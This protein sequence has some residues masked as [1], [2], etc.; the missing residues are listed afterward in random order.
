[1]L[2]IIIGTTLR[3]MWSNFT[4]FFDFNFTSPS[5]MIIV[6]GCLLMIVALFGCMGAMKES[7]CFINVV[8]FKTH[9]YLYM[10]HG[11]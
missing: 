11:D 4:F 5:M 3:T 10:Q 7:T 8:S 2:L 1:M 9:E 6:T